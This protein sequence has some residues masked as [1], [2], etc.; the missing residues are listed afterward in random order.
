MLP[1]FLLLQASLQPVILYGHW[2]TLSSYLA[3]FYFD[4]AEP[5]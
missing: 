5:C 2:F 1:E 4:S 3:G